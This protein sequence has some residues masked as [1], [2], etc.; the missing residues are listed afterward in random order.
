MRHLDNLS[1]P[2]AALTEVSWRHGVTET[3]LTPHRPDP[4]PS[5]P[6]QHNAPISTRVREDCVA[7]PPPPRSERLNRSDPAAARAL[8]LGLQQ[9]VG[10][11]AKLTGEALELPQVLAQQVLQQLASPRNHR[12]QPPQR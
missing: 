1:S 5:S 10:P 3:M 2:S 11:D 4:S 7:A 12:S 6:Q 9:L 8:E